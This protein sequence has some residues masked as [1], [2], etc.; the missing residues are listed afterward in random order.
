MAGL[1][2]SPEHLHEHYPEGCARAWIAWSIPALFFLYEFMIRVLPGVIE[3]PLQ[4]EYGASAGD[5]GLSLS[6]YYYAYGPMQ[7]VVGVLL[8]RFGAR[9]PLAVAAIVCAVGAVCFAMANSLFG[10]GAGRFLMG[11]GSAFAYVGAVYVATIWFPGRRI[12]LI[13]GFTVTLGM[14]GAIL[15]DSLLHS[16]I[17]GISWQNVMYGF[18]VLGLLLAAMQYLLIPHRPRWFMEHV[19][20]SHDS[21][22]SVHPGMIACLKEVFR[23]RQTLLLGLVT[24]LVYLPIGTFAALWGI[25]YL[26]T[27]LGIDVKEAGPLVSLIFVGLAIG[28]PCLG[29]L[30]DRL[31]RRVIFF[32]IFTGLGVISTGLLLLDPGNAFLLKLSLLLIGIVVSVL[33]L[34]FPLAMDQGPCYARGTALTFVNL[35]QMIMAGVGQWGVG[36]LLDVETGGATD[37]SYTPDQF[38][39]ALLLLPVTMLLAF[40]LSFLLREP[41]RSR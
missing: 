35:T 31:G 10:L 29:W 1:T 2:H 33:V 24:G 14:L 26:T 28:G 7:L 16:L 30:S 15:A 40:G 13:S 25:P 18:A 32:P 20:A 34:A 4:R 3:L 11:F 12:A 27:T 22:G 19:H 17:N 5:L 8:D 21:E 38:R 36:V 41:K 23:N 39:T 37:P 6:F 9:I